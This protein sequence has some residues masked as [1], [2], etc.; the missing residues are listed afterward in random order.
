MKEFVD[1][2][3]KAYPID[4]EGYI[5]KNGKLWPVELLVR[6][7][8]G[9]VKQQQQ[10]AAPQ[11][12]APREPTDAEAWQKWLDM[13]MEAPGVIQRG[14]EANPLGVAGK[15]LAGGLAGNTYSA[16]KED[17]GLGR[18]AAAAGL[19]L[20]GIL[21][22]PFRALSTA[23]RLPLA[24][25]AANRL[26]KIGKAGKVSDAFLKP[27]NKS[28]NMLTNTV[29][30]M[31]KEAL[32]G[33]ADGIGLE[34]AADML[35]DRKHDGWDLLLAPLIGAAS[36]AGSAFAHSKSQIGSIADLSNASTPIG[37]K[38]RTKEQIR[39]SQYDS[40]SNAETFSQLANKEGLFATMPGMKKAAKKRKDEVGKKIADWE[41]T[42]EANKPMPNSSVKEQGHSFENNLLEDYSGALNL[43][44]KKKITEKFG[45]EITDLLESNSDRFQKKLK[46]QGLERYGDPTSLFGD[47]SKEIRDIL[48][49]S[50]GMTPKEMN[51]MRGDFMERTTKTLDPNK[52]LGSLENVAADKYAGHFKK[53]IEQRPETQQINKLNKEW[54]KES[55]AEELIEKVQSKLGMVDR[56]DWLFP[57]L[58]MN[59]EMNPTIISNPGLRTRNALMQGLGTIKEYKRQPEKDKAGLKLFLSNAVNDAKALGIK[60]EEDIMNYVRQRI[61]ETRPELL[62]NKTLLGLMETPEYQKQFTDGTVGV[63]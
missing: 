55:N 61:F 12:E 58:R 25:K 53:Q 20:L 16:W 54:S 9:K 51:R 30:N 52:G 8:K 57:N 5:E 27:I 49:N 17:A 40:E 36:G 32:L 11:V 63:K 46:E 3:G 19:D 59:P 43:S 48:L 33:A 37:P 2:N 60:K 47:D 44:E 18:Y 21:A 50:H 56:L 45:P 7:G 4:E 14:W 24:V 41:Q 13:V 29:R 23:S 1:N 6:D 15:T 39:N 62:Q 31:G 22:S 38:Q 26:S 35:D 34:L 28:P 10:P 42:P